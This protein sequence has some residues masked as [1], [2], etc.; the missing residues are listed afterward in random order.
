MKQIKKKENKRRVLL[1]DV[2]II[3]TIALAIFMIRIDGGSGIGLLFIFIPACC[4][5]GREMTI[6]FAIREELREEIFS[7]LEKIRQNI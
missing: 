2:L 6:D 7:K 5:W 1:W 4:F 3:L